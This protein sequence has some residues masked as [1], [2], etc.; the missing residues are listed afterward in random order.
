M[1]EIGDEFSPNQSQCEFH[2]NRHWYEGKLSEK[3]EGESNNQQEAH[4]MT[5][6]RLWS[7]SFALISR[8]EALRRLPQYESTLSEPKTEIQ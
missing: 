5:N 4:L 1:I 3:K 6:S 2:R 7:L 8:H